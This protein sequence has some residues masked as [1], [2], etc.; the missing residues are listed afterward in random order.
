VVRY[1]LTPSFTVT[2]VYGQ[3]LWMNV[4]SQTAGIQGL[5]VFIESNVLLAIA[6]VWAQ[7]LP[8]E[9]I[10]AT[11]ETFGNNPV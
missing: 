9:T 6:L 1:S 5:L 3:I 11:I 4:P 7:G 8:V 2:V 10:R